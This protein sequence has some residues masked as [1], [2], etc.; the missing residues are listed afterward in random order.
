[1]KKKLITA[2]ILVGV[3]ALLFVPIPTG[4][5]SDGGTRVYDALTYRIVKWNKFVIDPETAQWKIHQNTN[6]YWFNH[7]EIDELW[8]LAH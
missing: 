8:K 7:Q 6:V 3:L 5:A 1:M 4:T 2:A